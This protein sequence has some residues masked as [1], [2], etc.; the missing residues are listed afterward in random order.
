M[1][2]NSD[3]YCG[4]YCGAC[5]VAI[6]GVTGRADGFVACC[7]GVPRS[8]LTC[9]GCKSEKVYAGCRV[10]PFRSCAEERG[11]ARCVECSDYPCTAYKRWQSATRFL[12]HVGEAAPSLDSIAREGYDSW[13]SSQEQ[14]WSCPTCGEHFSWY[15]ATC[16]G[17]GHSLE[18]EAYTMKGWRKLLCAIILPLV[19]RKG[20]AKTP[21]P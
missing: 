19:Y 20:R 3:T 14:R 10:C 17:C 6:Y 16:A 9:D 7:T 4:I 21:H 11:V 5:S 8:A 13:L 1:Q 12:P 2:V 18:G 15:A